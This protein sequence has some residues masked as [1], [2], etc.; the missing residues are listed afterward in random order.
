MIKCRLPQDVAPEGSLER[1]ARS[2]RKMRFN[3]RFPV[4]TAYLMSESKLPPARQFRIYPSVNSSHWIPAAIDDAMLYSVERR[5]STFHV[6]VTFDLSDPSVS[7]SIYLDI[8]G[9]TP[10][11]IS[12]FPRRILV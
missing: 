1:M 12:G 4:T 2:L 11:V 6:Q 10:Q 3:S 9:F 7:S 5:Q 8:P